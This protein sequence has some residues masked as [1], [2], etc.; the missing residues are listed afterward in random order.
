MQEVGREP[1]LH[2]FSF[3]YCS[4]PSSSI[5]TCVHSCPVC[6]R[7]WCLHGTT[8]CFGACWL[9][10]FPWLL[11]GCTV[12]LPAGHHRHAAVWLPNPPPHYQ[13]EEMAVSR[14]QWGWSQVAKEA[15][16]RPGHRRAQSTEAGLGQAHPCPRF[17]CPTAPRL[18]MMT[19]G[20][21]GTTA[22]VRRAVMGSSQLW[23]RKGPTR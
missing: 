20:P 2:R 10:A 12:P 19:L 6:D 1:R 18:C 21:M 22:P 14:V 5:Q 7:S 13:Q 16:A 8:A 3:S 9:C 4:Q 11:C 15:A 17:T 23:T